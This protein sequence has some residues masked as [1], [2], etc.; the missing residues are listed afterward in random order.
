[1]QSAEHLKGGPFSERRNHFE[2]RHPWLQPAGPES[3]PCPALQPDYAWLAG[4][5]RPPSR[6]AA[7]EPPTGAGPVLKAEIPLH[8]RGA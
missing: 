5:S 2:G 4:Y 7:L 8:G 3:Y 6:S 1:M